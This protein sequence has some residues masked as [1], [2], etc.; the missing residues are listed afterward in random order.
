M[1]TN[2]APSDGDDGARTKSVSREVAV[3][4]IG[5]ACWQLFW[6]CTHFPTTNTLLLLLQIYIRTYM[7]VGVGVGVSAM[8]LFI[9][10]LCSSYFRFQCLAF[11]WES[12]ARS[13]EVKLAAVDWG[14][15]YK[16]IKLTHICTIYGIVVSVSISRFL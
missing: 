10:L 7:G 9:L 16:I 1:Q 14:W 3:E 12:W 6:K 11:I 4:V 5:K 8:Y 13:S 15:G 2:N